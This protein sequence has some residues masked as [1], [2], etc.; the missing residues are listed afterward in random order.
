MVSRRISPSCWAGRFISCCCARLLQPPVDLLRRRILAIILVLWLPVAALSII[1]GTFLSGHVPFLYD[2]DVHARFLLALPLLIGAELIVHRRIR[3]VVQEFADRNLIAPEDEPY[4][5]ATINL[6]LRLRN[7]IVAEL[8]LLAVSLT[9]GY[10]VWTHYGTLK[11][12]TWYAAVRNGVEQLTWAGWWYAFVSLPLARFILFRW[13]FRLSLWYLF[14]WRVSRLRLR[15][16][17]LH[18]DRAGGIGFLSAS[19]FAFAPVLVAQTIF[20]AGF[21]ANQIWH[22]GA[23]LPQFKLE[24]AG[25]LV[26]L[27][28]VVL[29]PLSFF[30]F[31]TAAAKRTALREYG[32]LASR[33]ADEFRQKWLHSS[34]QPEELLL[35][36]ADIQ[37]LAD[38]S[39]SY[40]VVREMG[41]LPF[42]KTVVLR[43][44]LL[45]ALPLFPLT[46][47]MIPLDEMIDR[48]IAL[49]L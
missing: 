21:I 17:A 26:L 11:D 9:G 16:N 10:W 18:P 47:T 28:L 42:G 6:V 2:L 20:A 3:E 7:S 8:L 45:I 33:Y 37:S 29:T 14:M 31:Q 46:L 40:D 12:T 44:A 25:M 36:S 22:S 35:G 30:V 43:L 27:L 24:I 1:G 48:A 32:A 38:L 41:L 13:Y 39:N 15:L 19:V 49:V 4:F 23:K 34:Q 5:S